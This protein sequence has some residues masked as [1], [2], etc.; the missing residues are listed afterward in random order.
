MSDRRRS[1]SVM[2]MGVAVWLAGCAGSSPPPEPSLFRL[3]AHGKSLAA[4]RQAAMQHAESRCQQG[5]P[6]VIDSQPQHTE[7]RLVSA[8]ALPL[9]LSELGEYAAATHEG[10]APGIVWRYYCR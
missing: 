5:E 9:A 3:E 1:S 2:A 8:S 7:P 10:D 6:V 4:A